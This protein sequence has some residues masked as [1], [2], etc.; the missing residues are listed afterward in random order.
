LVACG[1]IDFLRLPG[2]DRGLLQFAEVLERPGLV[3][4]CFGKKQFGPRSLSLV[5]GSGGGGLLP[6]I[7]RQRLGGIALLQ[8]CVDRLALAEVA[9]A[10]LPES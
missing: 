3:V 10:K 1:V 5:Y 9:C 7:I 4:Q 2:S 6:R 8:V